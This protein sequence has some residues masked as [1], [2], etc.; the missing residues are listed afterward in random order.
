VR[1]AFFR[2][3]LSHAL[4]TAQIA[5]SLLILVAAALFVRT[6]SNLQS[7][8]LGFNRENV[9][10]FQV[11]ARQAAYQ[12]GK[13]L[14]FY[15]KLR[16]RFEAVPGVRNASLSHASLITAGRRHPVSVSG[17]PAPD[18]RILY[19]GPGV[20][21]LYASVHNCF[22][23]FFTCNPQKIRVIPQTPFQPDFNP[24]YKLVTKS[25]I[26]SRSQKRR[27]GIVS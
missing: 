3:N 12:D 27:N 4:V 19:A 15:A 22:Q 13:L 21:D 14:A 24:A 5:M 16:D 26:L 7:S 23:L 8:Q 25:T 10:L 6:L 18:S 20:F 2:I 17:T 11:N 9:L 1:F